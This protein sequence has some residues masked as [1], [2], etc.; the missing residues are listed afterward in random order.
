MQRLLS[1]PPDKWAYVW[2][3][4]TVFLFIFYFYLG[5]FMFTTFA[6]GLLLAGPIQNITNNSSS[7]AGVS[8]CVGDV[9]ANSTGLIQQ[10]AKEPYRV[11]VDGKL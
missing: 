6:I 8:G 11:L 3:F 1:C 10:L 9:L 4:M 5:R 7:L 2:V